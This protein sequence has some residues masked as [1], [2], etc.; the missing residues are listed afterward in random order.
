VRTKSYA[1]RQMGSGLKVLR[2]V[3][4]SAH[5]WRQREQISHPFVSQARLQG[6]RDG[7]SWFWKM[8]IYEHP[9]KSAIRK[10][11]SASSVIGI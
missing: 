10:F 2:A 11:R 1:A 6:V 7:V 5:A 4:M 3:K 9:R 8:F